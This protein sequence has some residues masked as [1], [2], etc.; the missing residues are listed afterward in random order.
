MYL[1]GKDE[2]FSSCCSNALCPARPDSWAENAHLLC[3]ADKC[4]FSRSTGD[5]CRVWFPAQHASLG[6]FEVLM[7]TDAAHF[8]VHACTL[9]RQHILLSPCVPQLGNLMWD[10]RTDQRLSDYLHFT[11]AAC[12]SYASTIPVIPFVPSAMRTGKGPSALGA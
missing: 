3:S 7:C 8:Y 9:Y 5:V 10:A 4:T 6:G 12:Y 1:L 11:L 2:L